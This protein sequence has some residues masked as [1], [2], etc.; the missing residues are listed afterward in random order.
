MTLLLYLR[1]GKYDLSLKS[2]CLKSN[3]HKIELNLPS[4]QNL[5]DIHTNLWCLFFVK[6]LNRWLRNHFCTATN[7]RR[8]PF[9]GNQNFLDLT[10]KSRFF[11]FFPSNIFPAH[12]R[13]STVRRGCS[14][15][16]RLSPFSFGGF[17]RNSSSSH[18]LYS[19]HT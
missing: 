14:V 11:S 13:L 10:A 4:L 18:L 16:M 8:F 12:F 17:F 5:M 7:F 6:D 1:C 9:S 19:S 2:N 3:Y 15:R